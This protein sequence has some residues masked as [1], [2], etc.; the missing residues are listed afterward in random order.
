MA[1]RGVLRII[2]GGEL[3][4]WCPGCKSAHAVPIDAP[5]KPGW[6][7]NGDYERPTFTPSAN[8]D[9]SGYGHV[10]AD[11]QEKRCHCFVRNGNIE[12]LSDCSHALAGTT[13]AL[14]AF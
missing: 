6:S 12:F 4:W 5:G 2:E 3:A 13:V 14:E 7:F 11:T 9:Y 10:V 8:V 1:A